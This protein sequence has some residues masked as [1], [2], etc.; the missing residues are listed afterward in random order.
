MKTKHTAGT[1]IV[2][3]SGGNVI[4][5]NGTRF[6]NI[7]TLEKSPLLITPQVEANAALISAAPELLEAL[8]KCQFQLQTWAESEVWSMEDEEAYEQAQTAINKA[9][10]N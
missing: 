7:A 10:G 3:N 1:W 4:C 8:I 9:T 2:A 6:A 5:H